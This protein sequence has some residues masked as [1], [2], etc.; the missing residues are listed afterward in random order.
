MGCTERFVNLH[1]ILAQGPC[2]FSLHCSNLSLRA[3]QVCHLWGIDRGPRGIGCR[4][5]VGAA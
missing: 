4:E 1:G 5:R 3:A 2:S